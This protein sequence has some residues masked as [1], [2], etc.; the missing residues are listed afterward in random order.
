MSIHVALHHVTRY[1]Y[2]RAVS[3]GPQVVRLRPAPQTRTR[4]LSYA[5]HVNPK[6]HFLHWSQD[7]QGNYLA[8]VTFQEPVREFVV[9]VDIV[10][11]MA[12]VN[13]F[14]FFLEPFAEEF[15][16]SYEP[17]EL[18]CLEAYLTGIVHTPLL[19][20]FVAGIDRTRRRTIFFIVDVNRSLAEVIRYGVRLE[21][22][23][24][25][26]EETLEKR[27]GS[28]RDSAWLLVQ[29]FRHLGLAARF[30]SG[31]LLQLVADE[32]SLDGPSGPTAD[33]TDLH[34]WCEVFL[35]GAGWIGL[36]PTSGLLAGEGHIPLACSATA[37][38]AA[39]IS[40]TM[41]P[42]E[43]VFEHEMTLSRI[44]EEPRVTKPYTDAEWQQILR[45][46]AL[47]DGHL[48]RG[49]VRLTM[50][51]EPTFISLDDREGREWNG[52]AVGP[53]K[54][55][56]SIDLFRKLKARYAPEG[57]SHFGQ[58]KWYPGEQLP[59]F[60]LSCFWRKDGEPI[61]TKASAWAA[62]ETPFGATSGDGERFLNALAVE[63]GVDNTKIFPAFEDAFHFLWRERKLPS[64][65]EVGR[66]NLADPNERER[67][68]RV[69]AQ[70]L[71]EVVAHVLPLT[72]DGE[73]GDA[74]DPGE[75][76]EAGAFR[77]GLWYL[78]DERCF[79]A[80]G[81]SP[82]GYRLPLDSLPWATVR[83]TPRIEPID[84]ASEL[85]PLPKESAKA[86]R[87]RKPQ[88][89]EEKPAPKPF[90]S[91]ADQV[92]T[93]L[94]AEARGG[95]LYLFMPPL[96][97]LEAYLALV[98][99]A[100][101]VAHTLGIPVILEGYEPPK[102]PRVEVFRI[103]PD[104]GVIEANVHP[105]K[106]FTEAVQNTVFLYDTARES[107]LGTE[108]FLLDGRHAG[109]G[110]GNHLVLGGANPSDS[111]FL[112]RP[113]LLRSLILY[114]NDHPSLSYMFSGLFIGPTS[115][116]PRI[117]EARHDAL[118]EIELACRELDRQ[119]ETSGEPAAPWLVDR[120]FRNLLTD[121]TGNT[122]RTEICIDKLFS[123]DGPTG[124][125]GLVELRGFEMPP[126][127]RMS[128]AQQLL[129]RAII[130]RLW[131]RP[132]TPRQA[133]RWG[134]ALH[135][136]FMLPHWVWADFEDVCHD[137]QSAKLPILSS[138]FLPHAEFRFPR[139]GDLAACGM[140]LELRTAL[141]PWHVLGEEGSP[142]GTVRYV[143]SS[144]E[145]VQVKV[146][147]MS[148]DRFAV[149]CNRVEIP[150]H[151]TGIPGEGVAGVRYRAW[152]PPWCLHPTIP[153][154]AP[155]IF[156]F[157]DRWSGRAVA[158]C[159]YHVSHPGGRSYDTFPV[160]SFE[161]ESRRLGRFFREGHTPG[162]I[163]L[164]EAPA[165]REF[166]HALDLR[167]APRVAP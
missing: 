146:S 23:V 138:W 42:C 17:T 163:T 1:R 65:V 155:L 33:F 121:S 55:A 165:S 103:T 84:F 122:H 167:W 56:L 54:R 137:L 153:V 36:D 13:P 32:K 29:I 126:H 46:G 111:P 142:G 149:T 160:N 110:G 130:A 150:L 21:P 10:A 25:T 135:D 5:L 47:V 159:T 104:P 73:I 151:S 162:P 66:S 101:S 45:V 81:D 116:A 166:P 154:D 80:P 161:A 118:F 75:A 30:V 67:L 9:E 19:T 82:V 60:A 53:Q 105:V 61:W 14:D 114:W 70:G 72:H 141:E 98:H 113:D 132:Y 26:P 147:G 83:D 77:T 44:V 158:G 123:P 97:T 112:R 7:P 99:A 51:G 140:T 128:V 156:D 87:A 39:P 95:T 115:Q 86:S 37:E 108:K 63:L 74:G 71:N 50:G 28:C 109:T 79:L 58:G 144:L 136:R 69:F 38:Q 119:I 139:I 41:D 148:G 62:E 152:Q 24:Q 76:G 18:R 106:T 131:E 20:A 57:L 31:Y 90:E 133:Q 11:E 8:R 48:E 78:R 35:P 92:R 52:D 117:D 6:N 134:T 143:D 124:R 16:F 129:V 91:A 120:L 96:A 34:A 145:R 59:R 15:P 3:L 94:V 68:R 85:P 22:G 88:K 12:V 157:V 127:A 100:E 164:R 49:D 93:A 107:R 40:G 89:T 27:S 4:I 2:S 102:D 43:V 64:N 125:L